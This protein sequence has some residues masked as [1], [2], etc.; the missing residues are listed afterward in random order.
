MPD[1]PGVRTPVDFELKPGWRLEK[2]RFVSNRGRVFDPRDG[3]PPGSRVVA[4]VP[5]LPETEGP[6]SRHA[7]RLLRYFQLILPEHLA[8][9]EYVAVVRGWPCVA[10]AHVAPTISLPGEQ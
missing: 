4:K 2:G 5:G 9:Q 8:P 10:A 3:L 1:L 6:P 7:R